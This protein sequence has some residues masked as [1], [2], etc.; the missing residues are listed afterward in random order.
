MSRA[1]FVC[2]EVKKNMVNIKFSIGNR[3]ECTAPQRL[4]PVYSH[5]FP[6]RLKPCPPKF[7]SRI[8]GETFCFGE[9]FPRAKEEENYGR[10]SGGFLSEVS[11]AEGQTASRTRTPS[12]LMRSIKRRA[13]TNSAASIPK[14]R[15]ITGIPG[16][17]V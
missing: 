17:G 4:K 9:D 16:P 5:R 7:N 13:H 10:G 3:N 2:R 6:A 1:I 14:P 15:R 8:P 12:F 11:E